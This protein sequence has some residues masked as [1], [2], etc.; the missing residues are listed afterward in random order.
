WPLLADRL[1]H[2]LVGSSASD[3]YAFDGI[4]ATLMGTWKGRA[5]DEFKKKAEDVRAFWMKVIANANH[6]AE[7][8]SNGRNTFGYTATSVVNAMRD[9]SKKFDQSMEI[10]ETWVDN[11]VTLIGVLKYRRWFEKAYKIPTFKEFAEIHTSLS[12]PVTGDF[13]RF[14]S[15]GSWT[16]Q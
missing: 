2:F 9:S 11:I 15:D 3:Q 16:G 5:A 1:Q 4:L 13:G 14:T 12:C 7:P 10:W 6:I 8:S